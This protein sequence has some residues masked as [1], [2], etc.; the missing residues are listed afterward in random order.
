MLSRSGWPA[1][2]SSPPMITSS[3]SSTPQI[4]GQDAAD[5]LAGVGDQPR[6]ARVPVA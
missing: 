5:G 1:G 4:A 2:A 6:R 3:G